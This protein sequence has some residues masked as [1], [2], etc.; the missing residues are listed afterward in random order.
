M[1]LILGSINLTSAISSF[2]TRYFCNQQIIPMY[3]QIK[4][5][6][7]LLIIFLAILTFSCSSQNSD[8]GIISIK[9]DNDVIRFSDMFSGY[10]IIHVDKD[11]LLERI[12]EIFPCMDKYLLYAAGIESRLFILNADGKLIRRVGH[13][14]SGPGEYNYLKGIKVYENGDI[15]LLNRERRKLMRYSW[16]TGRFLEETD[17]NF[18]VIPDDMIRLNDETY[19]LFV[20]FP[21]LGSG[22]H[23]NSI[24][25]Y[26]D[27]NKEIINS[28]IRPDPR[29]SNYLF[30]G[31]VMNLYTIDKK[32]RFYTVF[33]D[34]IYSIDKKGV[35]PEYIFDNGRYHISENIL[36]N[37]YN[38]VFEFGDA[39]TKAGCIWDIRYLYETENHFIFH[40]QYRNDF[41]NGL[42]N[43]QS[44]ETI[45]SNAFYDDILR[46]SEGKTHELLSIAGRTERSVFLKV[47]AV[48][49]INDIKDYR[50]RCK[51]EE[52][53]EYVAR[54]PD[55]IALL[56]AL[57]VEDNDLLIEFFLKN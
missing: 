7:K 48:T 36:Y 6:K 18:D 1:A 30:F 28:A 42:Y 13:T 44:G 17:I 8:P 23:S 46:M 33:R 24:Y 15:E 4:A 2:K 53:D 54:N 34:T 31:E 55:I 10:K 50:E 25:W 40:Y 3:N 37:D 9:P 5:P 35:V 19:I 56:D 39:C 20:K 26:S 32:V 27:K 21:S 11:L 16:D 41:Y 38:E 29:L 22:D 49:L 52:W 57:T 47:P 12:Y 51:D 45:T 14:G 43:K